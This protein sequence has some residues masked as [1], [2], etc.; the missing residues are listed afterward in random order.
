MAKTTIVHLTDDLDGNEAAE[1]LTFG[2]RGVEYEIDLS[3]KNV[4]ALEKA[5]DKYIAAGRRVSRSRPTPAAR[6]GR[7]AGGAK[8]DLG[9]L[10]EWARD[11]GYSVSDRGRIPGEIR[12]AYEAAQG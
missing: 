6:R 10:R 9:A 1:A 12:Q 7:S 5:L 3:A 8:Q 2:L 4:A 11:H